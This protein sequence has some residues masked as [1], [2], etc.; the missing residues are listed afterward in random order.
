MEQNRGG[1]A[2]QLGQQLR[3]IVGKE[4]FSALYRG[5]GPNFAGSTVSWGKSLSPF[6]LLLN[7]RSLLFLLFDFKRIFG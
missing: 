3:I 2:S 6:F 4:G 7:L 5:I 1:A